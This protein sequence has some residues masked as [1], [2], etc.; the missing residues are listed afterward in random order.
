MDDSSTSGDG[1]VE[2]GELLPADTESNRDSD[3]KPSDE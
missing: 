1:A 2:S 3:E